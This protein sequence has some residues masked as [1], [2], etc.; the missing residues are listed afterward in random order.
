L[1][2]YFVDSTIHALHR[3]SKSLIIGARG[4]TVSEDALLGMGLADSLL[5]CREPSRPETELILSFQASQTPNIKTKAIM[6]HGGQRT[7]TNTETICPD[8]NP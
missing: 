5:C 8:S 3:S 1:D 7:I 2:A 6:K 4:G